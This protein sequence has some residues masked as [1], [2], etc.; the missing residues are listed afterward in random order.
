VIREAEGI[1]TAADID[2][3]IAIVE[4][5]LG[6]LHQRQDAALAVPRWNDAQ[7]VVSE[8][9]QAEAWIACLRRFRSTLAED[10]ATSRPKVEALKAAFQSAQQ[11]YTAAVE[12]AL[13]TRAAARR[14]A[15]FHGLARAADGGLGLLR[16]R[17]AEQGRDAKPRCGTSSRSPK[18]RG[19]SAVLRHLRAAREAVIDVAPRFPQSRA[20]TPRRRW[21]LGNGRP[22]SPGPS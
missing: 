15:Q 12:M 20:C 13:R 21:A 4:R 9:V 14:R 2:Q 8:I 22:G 3:T 1:I 5:K 7:A 19:R 11:Q 16:R 17:G 18:A 10:I 6:E